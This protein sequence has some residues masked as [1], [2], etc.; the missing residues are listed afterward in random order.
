MIG[1]NMF[2][3]N[4]ATMVEIIQHYLVTKLLDPN[5]VVDVKDVTFDN[6][7]YTFKVRTEAAAVKPTEQ[8]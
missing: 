5:I 6:Q 1:S 3:F 7:N 2:E 8:K 4:K